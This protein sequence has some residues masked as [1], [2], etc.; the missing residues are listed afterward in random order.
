MYFNTS[1]GTCG[2]CC[3]MLFPPKPLTLRGSQTAAPVTKSALRGSQ[4][5]ARATKS[6]LQ[7]P[8]STAPATKSAN[9]PHVMSKSHDS[10]HLSR[11]Q[12]AS[13]I[14][15]MSK[16]LHLP[17]NLHFKVKPLRSPAPVT[18]QKST[19]DHQNTRFPLRTPRKVTII[20]ENAH[21][22]TTRAQSRQSHPRQPIRFCEPAQSKCTSRISRGMTYSK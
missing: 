10:M 13:K 20:C 7:G 9:Y 18:I 5:A 3:S 14:A 16:V 8:Q 6:A 1:S 12:S 2:K 17:R 22:T 21:G 11:N 19:L 15:T 4:C